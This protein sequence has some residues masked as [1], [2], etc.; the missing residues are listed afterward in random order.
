MGRDILVTGSR[1][2]VGSHLCK[3][4]LNT[5]N[6]L[7]YGLD[8]TTPDDALPNSSQFSFISCDIGANFGDTI[9][10]PDLDIIIHLA[11]DM[12]SKNLADLF[13]VNTLGTLRFL[14][15]GR[16][17][18]ICTFI[19]ASTGGVYGYSDTPLRES[20]PVRPLNGYTIS[21]YAAEQLVKYF[22]SFFSTMI[23]R[24][25]FPYGSGQRGRL[26]PALVHRIRTGQPITI[27]PD[28]HPR[29]NPV[30]VD[31]VVRAIVHATK[32][33]GHHTLNIAGAEI[34]TIRQIAGIIGDKLGV[35]AEFVK[36]T[37]SD[38]LGDMVGDIS[39]AEKTLDWQPKIGFRHGLDALL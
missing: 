35:Q 39:L 36:Q 22:S 5:T 30:H 26:I 3:Y 29:I 7:V 8:C 23:L 27:H 4:Y 16:R 6:E 31:D 21:K 28:D 20:S 10:P 38:V 9:L 37:D 19:F 11:A 2:L 1:G 33:V 32:L 25:F 24:L 18:G 17:C 12:D 14:E 34:F 13:A 15:Y